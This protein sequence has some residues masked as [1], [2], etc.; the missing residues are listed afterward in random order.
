MLKKTTDKML[1]WWLQVDMHFNDEDYFQQ[2]LQ[3]TLQ[4]MSM[5][6]KDKIVNLKCHQE[7]ENDLTVIITGQV[8][9]WLDCNF[10]K[11]VVF[12]SGKGDIVFCILFA[13][14]AKTF[15]QADE[16]LRILKAKL[17][18]AI[19][20][21]FGLC[22]GSKLLKLKLL[23]TVDS[24]LTPSFSPIPNKQMVLLITNEDNVKG[25]DLCLGLEKKFSEFE[26]YSS[27][28]VAQILE[29]DPIREEILPAEESTSQDTCKHPPKRF[30]LK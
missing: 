2:N 8:G 27:P 19:Y 9:T 12:T 10:K 29:A 24:M 28:E 13:T 3:L 15:L 16:A 21:Q 23:A 11:C 1:T 14:E 26:D 18:L 30:K 4:A 20:H 6:V 5:D 17:E 25:E 7:I 22:L